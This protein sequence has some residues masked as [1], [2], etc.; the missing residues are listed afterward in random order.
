LI[1]IIG[2]ASTV[3]MDPQLITELAKIH[4]GFKLPVFSLSMITWNDLV[5]G[6]LLFTLPQIPLTLGNAM[7][8]I[9][10]ENNELFP[11]LFSDPPVDS[12]RRI[13]QETGAANC[14]AAGRTL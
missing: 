9:V 4:I 14:R 7:I 8:A 12:N 13:R 10:A 1:K 6:T 11:D 5:V 3:I 2:V